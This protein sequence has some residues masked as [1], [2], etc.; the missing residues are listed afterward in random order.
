M[1]PDLKIILEYDSDKKHRSRPANL[2]HRI[3]EGFF[4][5][6]E[7]DDS[8]K[9]DQKGGDPADCPHPRPELSGGGAEKG[10]AYAFYHRTGGVAP[11]EEFK[12]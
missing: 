11:V 12:P 10:I 7:E 1:P 4:D 5:S 3:H 9:E 2:S 6:A 8:G